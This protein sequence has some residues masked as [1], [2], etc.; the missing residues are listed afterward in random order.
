MKMGMLGV[1]LMALAL[2]GSLAAWADPT[3]TP[4]IDAAGIPIS[5]DLSKLGLPGSLVL[6]AAIF[7][8]DI[9]R[10]TKSIS[11]LASA[12]SEFLRRPPAMRAHLVH[13]D[14]PRPRDMPAAFGD[15][16]TGPINL[17]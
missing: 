5:I 16:P 3:T 15:D 7:R 12:L 17:D 10:L 4:T 9:G 11:D 8:S 1:S 13:Y 6:I 2:G 14:R